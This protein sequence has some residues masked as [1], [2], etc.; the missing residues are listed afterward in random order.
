MRTLLTTTIVRDTLMD[1]NIKAFPVVF[2]L[3]LQHEGGQ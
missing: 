2:I 3:E 1:K